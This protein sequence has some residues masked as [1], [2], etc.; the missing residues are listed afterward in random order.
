MSS[1][2]VLARLAKQA[3]DQERQALQRINGAMAEHEQRIEDLRASTATE[4][5]CGLDFMTTGATL[6]AY[7]RANKLRIEA[8]A[9][10]LRNLRAAHAVQ[11]QKLQDKR[12]EL[13]RY[14]LL[15]ER[16][17]QRLAEDLAAKEQKAIDELVTA[18]AGRTPRRKSL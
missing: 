13:K 16:R 2:D 4:A 5:A 14:E 18:K 15:I 12:V 6:P 9:A 17:E 11:L 10:Q 8:V 1:L 3:V 7:L